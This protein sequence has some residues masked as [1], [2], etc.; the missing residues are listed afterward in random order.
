MSEDRL[1]FQD[2]TYHPYLP[3]V[4]YTHTEFP[5]YLYR[6]QSRTSASFPP[7]STR[8]SIYKVIQSNRSYP[9]APMGPAS[10]TA[11][12]GLVGACG[13]VC[14]PPASPTSLTQ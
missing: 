2:F 14:L 8:V 5:T 10:A 4:L 6:R 9:P 12:V 7:T 11:A 1:T 3:S 13:I